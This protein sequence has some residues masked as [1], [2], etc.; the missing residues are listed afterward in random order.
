MLWKEAKQ[1]EPA[2]TIFSLQTILQPHMCA[3]KAQLF[4][5]AA[6][7]TLGHHLMCSAMNISLNHC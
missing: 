7:T 1:N 3:E 5:L 2:Q 4:G 6:T